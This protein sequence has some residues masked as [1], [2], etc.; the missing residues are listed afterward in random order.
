VN[1]Y[2]EDLDAFLSLAEEL[3]LKGLNETPSSDQER[4]QPKYIAPKIQKRKS[5]IK[6]EIS[7]IDRNV[8]QDSDQIQEP[9]SGRLETS[10]VCTDAFAVKTRT[11]FEDLDATVNSMMEKND[12]RQWVCKVC[13][14]NDKNKGHMS[15]HIEG[16]HIDGVSHPC[17]LCGK[18]FRSRNAL[19]HHTRE[20]KA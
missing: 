2:L 20:H 15:D 8:W 10:L 6:E 18:S 7:N 17:S 1:I 4:E 14:K 13:G 11:N 9:E 5:F 12:D 3:Q 16:K 19:R